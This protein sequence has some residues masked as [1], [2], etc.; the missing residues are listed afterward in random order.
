MGLSGCFSMPDSLS[1]LSFTNRCPMKRVRPVVGKAGQTTAAG[2]SRASTSASQTGP[3][4]PS[5]VELNVEQYLYK[6]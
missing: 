2:T 6:Y 1:S 4:L 3:I 5:G